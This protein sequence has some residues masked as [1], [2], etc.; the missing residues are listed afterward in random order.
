MTL[1]I[2]AVLTVNF[3]YDKGQEP[4]VQGIMNNETTPSLSVP[5]DS[6]EG[7]MDRLP[8]VLAYV[9]GIWS[10]DAAWGERDDGLVFN[11]RPLL[12]G[13]VRMAHDLVINSDGKMSHSLWLFCILV[14]LIAARSPL[15][16]S[17]GDLMERAER[18]PEGVASLTKSKVMLIHV[19]RYVERLCDFHDGDSGM[20]GGDNHGSTFSPPSPHP[21][22]S[23]LKLD[24]G[25]YT[26]P[27]SFTQPV[28]QAQ[29][30]PWLVATPGGM[31]TS[32]ATGLGMA[33][34]SLN[35]FELE[36]IMG[37][38]LET[39]PQDPEISTRFSPIPQALSKHSQSPSIPTLAATK[40]SYQATSSKSS[41]ADHTT[42][43]SVQ[44]DRSHSAERERPPKR[45]RRYSD[46]I[47]TNRVD[48][49]ELGRATPESAR[50]QG[51][52]RQLSDASDVDGDDVQTTTDDDA[53]HRVAML[54]A[55]VV[56]GLCH[57]RYRPPT[58]R[59]GQRG[60][61][62]TA[63]E[64]GDLLDVSVFRSCVSSSS[65][66]YVLYP[67]WRDPDCPSTGMTR[68][69]FCYSGEDLWRL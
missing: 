16:T 57:D 17:L 3:I 2:T 1:P 55:R 44:R 37:R 63:A 34:P 54:L 27:G 21:A 8:H 53:M 26:E 66:S 40:E 67:R 64:L 38:P 7:S 13:P 36:V 48:V 51:Q 20:E 41:M 12:T 58:L 68:V 49:D 60:I 4:Y 31:S 50:R 11:Q 14:A 23:S 35:S 59:K 5:V 22:P 62:M 42:G 6:W 32:I 39:G 45:I 33:N 30:R 29:P 47:A 18:G 9:S 69:G 25:M 19:Q 43:Y 10:W 65:L 28:T 56:V 52:N 61:G 15:W 24:Y 46:A